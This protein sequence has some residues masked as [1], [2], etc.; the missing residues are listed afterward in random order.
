[1]NS[2]NLYRIRIKDDGWKKISNGLVYAD[3]KSIPDLGIPLDQ[4]LAYYDNCFDRM[5]TR[6][7]L[8]EH[9]DSLCKTKIVNVNM[10]NC[11]RIIQ[12]LQELPTPISQQRIYTP[13]QKTQTSISRWTLEFGVPHPTHEIKG[14]VA[15]SQFDCL[16]LGSMI[17]ETRISYNYRK[18][19]ISGRCIINGHPEE[20]KMST[21]FNSRDAMTAWEKACH[22]LYLE[23]EEER[24]VNA[25]L[26]ER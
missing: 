21:S 13:G 5:P 26:G 12:S 14:Y 1:M 10:Q 7:E 18:N 25:F 20:I 22:Q 9:I 2:R 23:K 24:T 16:I 15:A 3:R 6:K 19:E 4:H 11:W 8:L 17:D